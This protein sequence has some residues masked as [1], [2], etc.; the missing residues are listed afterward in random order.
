MF[1]VTGPVTSSTS[2]WRG[3]ATNFR[4]KR[5]TSYTGLLSA[6][7]SSSQPLHEPA[8]TSRI[9][10]LRPRRRRAA[11]ST[12]RASS[13]AAASS[14][15]GAVSV[16]GARNIPWKMCLRIVA[17]EI[18]ARI[19][20]VERF[21]AERKVGD[22]VAFDRG[23]EQRPLEP[24]RVAQMAARDGAVAVEPQPDQHVAAEAFD[25]RQTFAGLVANRQLAARRTRRQARQNLL[26]EVEALL[27]LADADP[28]A[29]VDVAVAALRHDEAQMVVGRVNQVAAG[30]EIAARGATDIA[31]GAVLPRQLRPEIA[32]A[33]G[34]ILQ[35][36]GV[37]VE[38]DQRRKA[39]P[40]LGDQ[41]AD[42][43]GARVVEIARDAARHDAVAHHPVAESGVGCAQHA[44]AQHAG[45]GVHQAEGGVVADRADVAE[46]VGE[47][48]ELGHQ[49]AQPDRP[50]RRFAVERGLGGAGE[51]EG[52]GDGAVA[53]GASGEPRAAFERGALHQAFDALVDVAEPLLEPHHGLAGG[54]ETEIA[55][56]DDAGVDRADDD[57]MQ[58][59]AFGGTKF[60]R[61]AR[62]RPRT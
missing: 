39:P 13:A 17:S 41:R 56:L 42:R 62:L 55:R 49:G 5:S 48:L 43:R 22:D 50:R 1:Q 59:F 23:F 29:R 38:P 10:R 15:D 28:D 20:A 36:R 44:F 6:W 45:M 3:E 58:P 25:Q 51:S 9:D 47:A 60:V 18:V 61:R 46:V 35:R 32:G 31:A 54:M 34:A 21:V 27:R 7:I 12:A 2:A 26:D 37:V 24:R 52:I 16:S 53:R 8:S 30:V 57:A 4:P 11:R 33:D 40:H 14:G 19:G